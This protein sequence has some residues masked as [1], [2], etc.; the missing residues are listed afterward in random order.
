MALQVIDVGPDTWAEGLDFGEFFDEPDLVA[1]ALIYLTAGLSS[2]AGYCLRFHDVP[3]GDSWFEPYNGNGVAIQDSKAV[4]LEL[5]PQVDFRRLLSPTFE[6]P[7][8]AWSIPT[9]PPDVFPQAV[10]RC[11]VR[12]RDKDNRYRGFYK[13]VQTGDEPLI[14]NFLTNAYWRTKL[15]LQS[16]VERLRRKAGQQA[17]EFNATKQRID[18]LLRQRKPNH[19]LAV[20]ATLMTS[21]HGS[22]FNRAAVFVPNSN[23]ELQCLYAH[24]GDDSQSW[25]DI[26]EFVA[27][28]SPTISDLHAKFGGPIPQGDPLHKDLVGERVNLNVPSRIAAVWRSGLSAAPDDETIWMRATTEFV[29]G[30]VMSNGF[31]QR[32]IATRLTHADPWMAAHRLRNPGSA[33]FRSRN[34]QWFLLPWGS[35]EKPIGIWIFDLACWTRWDEG[36][37]LIPKLCQAQELL[38]LFSADFELVSW[39]FT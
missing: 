12:L 38:K 6:W 32:P 37:D 34:H 27:E 31:F 23:N 30:N 19:A 28:E 25:N 1:A 22:Q 16:E 9:T 7:V 20:L 24:G 33:V 26:R 13:I 21:Q 14:E 3:G 35:P 18:E 39:E 2:T 15:W 8:L 4:S 17:A 5:P 10:R 11:H 29:G 36:N